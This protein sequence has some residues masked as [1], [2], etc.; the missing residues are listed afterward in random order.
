M[1]VEKPEGIPVELIKYIN[2][3]DETNKYIEEKCKI[4]N[5]KVYYM[6]LYTPENVKNFLKKRRKY[7]GWFIEDTPSNISY[8][9]ETNPFEFSMIKISNF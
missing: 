6:T 4:K 9:N 2:E 3:I 5:K 1:V 8:R 7:K